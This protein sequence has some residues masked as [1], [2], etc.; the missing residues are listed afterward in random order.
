MKLEP[1]AT[2]SILDTVDDPKTFEGMQQ[3]G[4]SKL[5]LDMAVAKLGDVISPDHCIINTVSPSAVKNTDLMREATSWFPRF[6]VW[7]M[8]TITGRNMVDAPRQY[9]H[10]A[11]VLG[12]DS[13]GS[14][15]DWKIKP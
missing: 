11:L 12:K 5:F 14:F 3:Y 9:L 8:G 7:F 6:F 15:V 2:K 13:Y 4:F 10:A 1:P